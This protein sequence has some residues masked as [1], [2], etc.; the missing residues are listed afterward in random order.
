[1]LGAHLQKNPKQVVAV[2]LVDDL[3]GTGKSAAENFERL[4]QDEN[5]IACRNH[6]K[7]FLLAICG[8]E[9]GIAEI[10]RRIA[11]LPLQIEVH[12]CDHLDD[13]DRIFSKRTRF[14]PDVI[15]RNEALALCKEI[16]STLENK[17]PLGYGDSQL[18]V[19]FEDTAPNNSLP[20]LWKKKQRWVALFPRE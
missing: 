3:I 18:A 4:A 17:Q 7:I 16:G 14:F 1:M 8:L 12:V 9:D 20:I 5:V 11:K 6:V 13:K 15:Q 2:V 19:I 10:E